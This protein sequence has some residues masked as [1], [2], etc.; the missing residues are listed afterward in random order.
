MLFEMNA[1]DAGKLAGTIGRFPIIK[2][3][4]SGGRNSTQVSFG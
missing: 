2:R 1:S 4:E 3:A